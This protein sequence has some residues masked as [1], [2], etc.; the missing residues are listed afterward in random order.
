MVKIQ[1]QSKVEEK[2]QEKKQWRQWK[3]KKGKNNWYQKGNWK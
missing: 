1:T 3:N 2:A